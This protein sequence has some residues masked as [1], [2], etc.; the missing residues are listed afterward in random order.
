MLG[1]LVAGRALRAY[2]SL[3]S[4]CPGFSD[5]STLADFPLGT[6]RPRGSSR[7][8]RPGNSLPPTITTLDLRHRRQPLSSVAVNAFPTR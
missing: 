2:G 1:R 7:T 5:G 4:R 6:D 8:R 3:A